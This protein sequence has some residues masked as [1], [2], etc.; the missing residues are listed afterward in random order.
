MTNLNPSRIIVT[1]IIETNAPALNMSLLL[2]I[3]VEKAMAFGGVETGK[4]IASEH[5]KAIV[6]ARMILFSPGITITIGI[7]RLA[8]A[9]L[10]MKVERITANIQ[11]TTT[12]MAPCCWNKGKETIQWVKPLISIPF[13][14]ANP[15]HIRIRISQLIF[16]KSSRLSNPDKEKSPA[17]KSAITAEGI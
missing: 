8:V 7:R 10:L 15:P 4:A 12:K 9:V 6:A 1:D 5:D 11:N 2:S 16:L 3:F 13:P 14:K 17:A